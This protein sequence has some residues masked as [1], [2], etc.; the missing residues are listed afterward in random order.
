MLSAAVCDLTACAAVHKSFSHALTQPGSQGMPALCAEL[1]PC[2]SRGAGSGK[3]TQ[4]GACTASDTRR[5]QGKP[6]MHSAP[7]LHGVHTISQQAPQSMGRHGECSDSP[8]SGQPPQQLQESQR[9]RSSWPG[10]CQR[11]RPEQ[12]LPE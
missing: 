10:P 2:Y 9:S 1:Q 3:M 5:T 12:S 7:I 4:A 6:C 11:P 8:G